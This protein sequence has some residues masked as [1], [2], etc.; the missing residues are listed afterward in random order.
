MKKILGL[1]IILSSSVSIAQIVYEP[2][3][4]DVYDFLDLMAQKGVIQFH[5]EIRPVSMEYNI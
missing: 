5:D 2:I 4:S 1:I 3:H